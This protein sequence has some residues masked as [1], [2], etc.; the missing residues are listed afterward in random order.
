MATT[1]AI[2]ATSEAIV[3]LLTRAKSRAPTAV[4]VKVV[5]A[6]ELAVPTDANATPLVT[7]FLHRVGMSSV[8]RTFP[9]HVTPAGDRMKPPVPLDF[10]YLI[11]AWAATPVTQQLL[12]GWAVRTIEDNLTLPATLLNAGTS[13]TAF[14]ADETVELTWAPL[15]STEETEIWQVAQTARQPSASYLARM[16]LIASEEPLNEYPHAQTTDFGYSTK[17]PA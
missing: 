6:G 16:V 2:A 12:L 15:T 7:V 14:R 17:V 9:A 3:A 10:S 4:D 13:T 11:T 8:Q 5:E 1:A